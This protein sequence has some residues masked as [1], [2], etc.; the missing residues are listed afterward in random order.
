MAV[1]LIRGS[2]TLELDGSPYWL[3]GFTGV[4]AAPVEHLVSQGPEQHGET[5]LDFRLRPRTVGLVIGFCGT[6]YAEWQTYRDGLLGFLAPW[7]GLIA[8]EFELPDGA[9][10]RLDC[11]LADDL[12]MP[13]ADRAGFYQRV[14]VSL[15]APDPTW[16]EPDGMNIVLSGGGSASFAVPTS[17]P[18]AVGRSTF[19][20]NMIISYGGTAPAYPRLRL[21]GPL[22]NAIVQHTAT[23]HKLDFTGTTITA[24][25]YYEIDCAY[26]LKT[27]VDNTGTNRI[28][29]L[30]ADSNLAQFAIL[31]HPLVLNGLNTLVVTA[32]SITDASQVTVVLRERFLG[33]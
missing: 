26:G 18:T 30:T 29:K 15:L 23:G 2:E 14:A 8:L 4:G 25:T 21:V 9:R 13:S 24:G 27:V 28:D 3:E 20:D 6:T 32:S 33:L 22:T 17:V 7:Y 31:P 12:D 19:A 10:R 1:R 16:Y 11:V 5:W